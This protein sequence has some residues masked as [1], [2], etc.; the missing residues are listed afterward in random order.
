MK[1]GEFLRG[2]ESEQRKSASNKVIRRKNKEGILTLFYFSL[3]IILIVAAQLLFVSMMAGGKS[4][5]CSRIVPCAQQVGKLQRTRKSS[6][7]P[8]LCDRNLVIP[9]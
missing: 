7:F 4:S 6:K 8:L 5:K 1:A 2:V 9:I 3:F